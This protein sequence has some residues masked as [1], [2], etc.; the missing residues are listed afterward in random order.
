MNDK[1]FLN[2]IG[3]LKAKCKVK[4]LAIEFGIPRQ[5]TRFFCPKCQKNGGKT[6]D[7]SVFDNGFKCYKCGWNGDLI[8]WVTD[9]LGMSIS[10]AINYL[11]KKLG[12]E[13]STDRYQKY[14]NHSDGNVGNSDI[15]RSLKA[16]TAIDTKKKPVAIVDL[17]NT[18]LKTI[19]LPLKE[20]P[21]A[22]YLESRKID[23][24]VANQ[25]MVRYCTDLSRLWTLTDQKSIKASGLSSF[26]IYQKANLPFLVFPYIYKGM[27]IFIKARCLL[28]KEE[29]H[30]YQ[31]PRFLNTGGPVP[32][33]WNHDAV[34]K[35][36][37]VIICEGE[38]D[39]L[40][41]IM[42]EHI[43]VG[44]PGW[45]HWKDSFTQDFRGKEVFLA[46]DSDP[47]GQKGVINIARRF[48]NAGLRC[49]R[50]FILPKGKDLNEF[51]KQY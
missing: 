51:L 16:T 11:G 6:P 39:A 48:M 46:L 3:C 33:L 28:S 19:C 24:N 35:A 50:Q 25:Y 30:C 5:G 23:P 45:S 9:N 32:C 26:Y 47:A 36:S 34:V 37:R 7:L 40:S 17:Y 12:I 10:E 21:G 4:E 41:A 29:A 49:P 8:K 44:L 38:I 1:S 20:T 14:Q 15:G 43:G 27:P 18:F 42:A 22:A 13:H 31:V 2:Y